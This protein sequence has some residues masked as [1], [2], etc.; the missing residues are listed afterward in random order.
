MSC[1]ERKLAA[2]GVEFGSSLGP[3]DGARRREAARSPSNELQLGDRTCP[4]PGFLLA[5]AL[6]EGSDRCF[7]L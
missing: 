2:V 6:L 3:F 1:I 5:L 4:Q 7:V